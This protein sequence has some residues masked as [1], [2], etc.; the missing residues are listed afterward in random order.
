MSSEPLSAR[1]VTALFSRRD[2]FSWRAFGL[3]LAKLTLG[4][5]YTVAEQRRDFTDLPRFKLGLL[6]SSTRT[7]VRL[8]PSADRVKW[9]PYSLELNQS[10]EPR[11]SEHRNRTKIRD[12]ITR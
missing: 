11:A 7:D 4:L 3:R 10:F 12:E 5:V 6:D 1:G 2:D 8:H 9:E